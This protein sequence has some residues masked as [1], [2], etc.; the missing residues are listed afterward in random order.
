MKKTTF[1][2]GHKDVVEMLV[3]NGA[4]INAKDDWGNTPISEATKNGEH[5]IF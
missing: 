1:F 4:D 2:I 3:R 5:S